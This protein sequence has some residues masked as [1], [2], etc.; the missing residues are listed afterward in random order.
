MP[1]Y[2]LVSIRC[3]TECWPFKEAKEDGAPKR[4]EFCTAECPEPRM[5]TPWLEST[6]FVIHA[7]S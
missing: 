5:L 2:G 3:D 1:I 7:E 6:R 4:F